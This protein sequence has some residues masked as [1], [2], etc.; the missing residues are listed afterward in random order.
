MLYLLAPPEPWRILMWTCAPVVLFLSFPLRKA[1]RWAWF[2]SLAT[3]P[4]YPLTPYVDLRNIQGSLNGG[5]A[6]FLLAIPIGLV[7]ALLVAGFLV[8][9]HR[10][11]R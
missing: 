7:V 4:L 1:R 8:A 11:V 9:G 2:A 10:A 3:T 5:E 6:I